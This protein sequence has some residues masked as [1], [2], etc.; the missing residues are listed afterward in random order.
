MAFAGI[1]YD[2]SRSAKKENINR[3]KTL[4]ARLPSPAPK[5]PSAG[6]DVAIAVICQMPF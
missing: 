6:P 1:Y 5:V 2:E 4:P 3:P